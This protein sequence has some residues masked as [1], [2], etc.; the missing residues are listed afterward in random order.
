MADLFEVYGIKDAPRVVG[1]AMAPIPA[2]RPG[3]Q[4]WGDVAVSAVQNAPRSA[5]EFGKAIAHPFLHPVQTAES[6]YAVGRGVGALE[7]PKRMAPV[8]LPN[9]Q[10]VY[11]PQEAP[12]TP[13]AR[14]RREEVA[15]PAVA[16]GQFY[17]DRY[18]SVEGFKNAVAQDPVGVLADAS[19][20]L[21]GGAALPARIPGAVGQASRTVGRVGAAID[22][23]TQTINAAGAGAGLGG[24]ALS[25]TLG[26]NT[27]TGAEAV[28]QA[29][30]AGREGNRTFLDHMR[31]N[32]PV[33]DVADMGRSAV[34]QI[35]RERNADYN[36]GMAPVLSDPTVRN[37]APIDQA[38]GNASNIGTWHG[39]PI[40]QSTNQVQQ[41]IGQ[42]LDT[43]R[44]AN[45]QQFHTAG[46]LDALKQAIGD[47][48]DSQPPHTPAR[49][50][51]DEMYRAVR[52][53]VAAQVPEYGRV[54]NAYRQASD[55]LDDL[56]R[57]FSLG[58]NS[59]DDTAIRKLQSVMRNNVQTNYGHRTNLANELAA[60][61]PNLPA[62]I[63][64]QAFNTATPRGLVGRMIGGGAGVGAAAM[65]DPTLALTALSSSPRLVGEM[66][67]GAGRAGQGASELARTLAINV[68]N[69]RGAGQAS[70]QS[71]RA[72][73]EIDKYTLAR[74]LKLANERRKAN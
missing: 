59:L 71:G 27:G 5:V 35:R 1:A 44:Q 3:E 28:Q 67:Y 11:Q 41:E 7:T 70:F 15:A 30:Q 57:T 63:A 60:R 2:S 49:A 65:F 10:T 17:K 13:E 46:G 37:F 45:P 48:R 19:T 40:R 73:D 33:T 56:E 8:T 42:V 24:R 23:L 43:W 36:A 54:M 22:P 72:D 34:G 25:N 21:T 38:F 66:T 31:G 18:G 52:G 51:A 64:G 4:S 58:A 14:A 53:E 50:F 74:A 39:V 68:P 26:F 9:G 69:V 20:V 62:A 55:Q 16:V 6:V 32:A 47:I 61:E 29:F 12:E